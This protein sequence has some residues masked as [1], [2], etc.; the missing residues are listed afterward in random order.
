LC[1]LLKIDGLRILL[2]CGWNDSFNTELL[3]PLREVCPKV[4]LV[5]ISFPDLEHMGALPYAIKEFGLCKAGEKKVPI[6]LTKAAADLGVLSLYDVYIS[7]ATEG[8]FPYFDLDDIDELRNKFLEVN[9]EQ[10]VKIGGSDLEVSILRAGRLLGGGMW[11]IK[12]EPE[13]ILYAVDFNHKREL[14]LDGAHD[15]LSFSG[16]QK[17]TV[18]IT[19]GFNISTHPRSHQREREKPR[20]K[21]LRKV[22]TKLRSNGNVLLPVDCAGRVL[23]LLIILER[24]WEQNKFS[25]PIIWA[26][27]VVQSAARH[28]QAHLEFTS[29]SMNE[30]FLRDKTNPFEFKHVKPVGNLE[31]M[32]MWRSPKVILCS[33]ADLEYGFSRQLF[34]QFAPNRSNLILFTDRTMGDNL[35]S[36]LCKLITEKVDIRPQKLKFSRWEYAQGEE[37]EQ[38]KLKEMDRDA[39]EERKLQQIESMKK[40]RL[41]QIEATQAL[42]DDMAGGDYEL[43]KIESE[44]VVVEGNNKLKRQRSIDHGGGLFA[45]FA[46]KLGRTAMF[47]A[48]EPF[49]LTRRDEYGEEIDEND[50]MK[51]NKDS[52]NDKEKGKNQEKEEEN[53]GEEN[54]SEDLLKR[55]FGDVSLDCSLPRNLRD[56]LPRKTVY[57]DVL[58]RIL[59]E[60]EYVDMEGRCTWND[61]RNIISNLDPRKVVLVRSDE[62]RTEEFRKRLCTDNKRRCL[63]PKVNEPVNIASDTGV[64]KIKLCRSLFDKTQNPLYDES[65]EKMLKIGDSEVTYVEGVIRK[66]QIGGRNYSVLE[67][68]PLSSEPSGVQPSIEHTLVRQGDLTLSYLQGELIEKKIKAKFANQVLVCCGGKV[69]IRIGADKKIQLTGTLCTEYFEIRDLIYN[70][71]ISV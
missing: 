7:R 48:P 58:V 43:L 23:E 59:C 62:A 53:G 44:P 41:Q 36:S 65:L 56:R 9:F 38:W 31:A 1:S 11:R 51:A 63:F 8:E 55:G 71:F 34:G 25:Y 68:L 42:R 13:D 20:D 18:M 28:V 40:R 27:H 46:A 24:Y 26:N 52:E 66:T 2:D 19:D 30:A 3:E 37:L 10:P 5:L 60:I 64:W 22:I 6:C 33:G 70:R 39:E 69:T 49:R 54:H 16:L 50:Y 47:S 45:I 61:T 57:S 17:P 67:P 12:R 35:T 32:N 14:H 15:S 29:K 4:D 21:F